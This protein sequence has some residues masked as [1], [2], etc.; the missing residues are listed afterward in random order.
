MM[1]L[2]RAVMAACLAFFGFC[3]IFMGVVMMFATLKSGEIQMSWGE[4]PDQT[5]RIL[6]SETPSDFWTYFSLLGVLPV[7]VG[8]GAIMGA[9]FLRRKG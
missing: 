9:G 1:P 6:L 7:A 2:F 8:L 4:A 3:A 5:R